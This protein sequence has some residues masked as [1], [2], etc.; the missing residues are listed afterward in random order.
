MLL[1]LHNLLLVSSYIDLMGRSIISCFLGAADRKSFMLSRHMGE[2]VYTCI[3]VRKRMDELITGPLPR[4][5]RIR[6]RARSR[7]VTAA[8]FFHN[9]V[10]NICRYMIVY[11][12]YP[13]R[14][15]SRTSHRLTLD[16]WLAKD[17]RFLNP[18]SSYERFWRHLHVG[19]SNGSSNR[20]RTWRMTS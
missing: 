4:R 3:A 15:S 12:R 20:Y 1:L 8:I 9:P 6:S 13:S 10:F 7:H 17:N 2:S 16:L 11:E 19:S 5:T 14:T 18:K